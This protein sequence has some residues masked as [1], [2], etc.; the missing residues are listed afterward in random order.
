MSKKNSKLPTTIV[1]EIKHLFNELAAFDVT[2]QRKQSSTKAYIQVLD[3]YQ[4]N[5][6]I[7][8]IYLK[9]DKIRYRGLNVESG[10]I[11]EVDIENN[12]VKFAM[13]STL[14]MKL[15]VAFEAVN[16]LLSLVDK[17]GLVVVATPKY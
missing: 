8:T 7:H 13:Y 2:V 1:N 11:T 10:N 4:G 12:E 17:H 6:R 14:I 16:Q 9:D 15:P 3:E 5:E